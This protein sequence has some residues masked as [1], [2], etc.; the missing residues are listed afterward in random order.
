MKHID[1]SDMCVDFDIAKELKKNGY[2]QEGNFAFF[3]M[4]QPDGEII[5]CHYGSKKYVVAFAPCSDELVKQLPSYFD[6]ETHTPIKGLI[7]SITKGDKDFMINYG[8][9]FIINADKLANGLAKIWIC[10]KKEGYIN[11]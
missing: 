11:V 2:P 8:S 6:I 5:L 3:N 7:L 10:L 9:H 1:W 4:R